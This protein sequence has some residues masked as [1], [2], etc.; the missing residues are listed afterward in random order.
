M[1]SVSSYQLDT[2]S[3]LSTSATIHKK[4]EAIYEA[5]KAQLDFIDRIAVASYDKKTD[6]LKTFVFAG[7]DSPLTHY[8]SALSDSKS[9]YEIF[10]QKTPR[11]VN[12]IAAVYGG[13]AL[14]SAKIKEA[15]LAASY[16]MPIFHNG[17]FFGFVFFNSLT[18][19]TF[20]E[21]TLITLNV[22]GHLISSIVTSEMVTSRVL[23]AALKTANDM[24]HFKDPE[25]KAH[26]D[27]MSHFSR[28]IANKLSNDGGYDFTDE[29]VESVFLYAPM[30]D[31]GKVG[32]PDK[33]LLKPSRLSNEEFEIMKSH[34][35][36]GRRIVDAMI[37]NFGLDMLLNVNI[38]RNITELHHEKLDGTGYPRGLS[39][40]DIPPEAK[41]VAVA[42]VFDALTSYR[43]YKEAWS[44]KE[45]FDYLESFA[46]KHFDERCIKAL[47]DCSDEVE[48]IQKKF[49]DTEE[50]FFKT[51]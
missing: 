44:N 9:L 48:N 42:D 47:I 21:E 35:T 50:D 16:T 28:I 51:G 20:T 2:L 8:E 46:G 38:L 14:H 1:D 49:V 7:I 25:T 45:A 13:E 26:L 30:H 41:I 36:M 32:I 17:L 27:R 4:V 43:P 6:N 31:V 37:V 33:I 34:T 19:N 22:Y 39:G 5:V 40:D 24:I 3:K 29:F 10:T 18:P 23:I 12:D 11:V 15:G